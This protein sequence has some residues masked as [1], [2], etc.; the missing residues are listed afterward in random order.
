MLPR[1]VD[2]PHHQAWSQCCAK[3]FYVRLGYV[4]KVIPSVNDRVLTVTGDLEG[5]SKAYRLNAKGLIE[6]A[7]QMGMVV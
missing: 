7:P 1:A 4:S 3:L 5:I 2:G 6:G